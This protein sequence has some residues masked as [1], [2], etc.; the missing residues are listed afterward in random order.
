MQQMKV[1]DGDIVGAMKFLTYLEDAR[2]KE[3]VAAHRA[4]QLAVGTNAT[5]SDN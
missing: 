2:D 3:I 4:T 5:S 1:H